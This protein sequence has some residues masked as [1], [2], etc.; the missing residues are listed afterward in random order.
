MEADQAS[1]REHDHPFL[2]IVFDSRTLQPLNEHRRGGGRQGRLTQEALI[3]L[4]AV[5]RAGGQCERC[6]LLKKKVNIYHPYFWTDFVLL[7]FLRLNALS[8]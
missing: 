6:R 4:Q 7:L 1:T 3:A 2:Q 8:S 5:K